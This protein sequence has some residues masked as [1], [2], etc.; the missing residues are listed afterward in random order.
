[1]KHL[2]LTALLFAALSAEALGQ[3]AG[4]AATAPEFEL[5]DLAGRVVKLSDYKGKVVLINFWATWC[6]PCRAEMPE[7]VQLQKENESRGLQIVGVTYPSYSR[8]AVR[9]LARKMK[10]NYP[11]LFGTRELAAK[12]D[13]GEVLPATVVIDREGKI[14][15]LILGI[16]QPEEFEQII[17]PLFYD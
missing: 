13:V 15:G 3:S 17:K 8:D 10:L 4:Q 16:L 9:R 1:M 7:L 12:Y 14:R 6:P 2:I 5:K 11:I